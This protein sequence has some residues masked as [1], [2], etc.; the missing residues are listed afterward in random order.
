MARGGRPQATLD[1]AIVGAGIIGLA[2]ALALLRNRPS[3]RLAI[4]EQETD[5][6]AHQ[7]G[8][9][10][11]VLHAGLYYAPGSLK[12][13]LCTAGKAEMERYA[14]EHA[15]PFQRVGKLVIA[16]EPHELTALMALLDRPTSHRLAR[17]GRWG[18]ARDVSRRPAGR[19]YHRCSG[20]VVRSIGSNDWR[21]WRRADR[22]VPRR[23][24][25][26]HRG[27]SEEH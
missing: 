9:N 16:V 21:R 14:T 11:G 20:S 7:T 27:R 19:Q 5:I 12:A 6:A 13:R 22:A 15:V 4:V 23:L 2:T 17:A 25:P 3:L 26:A 8:H 1:V 10:S 24:L 18:R